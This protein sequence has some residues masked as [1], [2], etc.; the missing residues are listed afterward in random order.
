MDNWER[1]G[2]RL[3]VR[4][5]QRVAAL[6]GRLLTCKKQAQALVSAAKSERSRRFIPLEMV[7]RLPETYQDWCLEVYLRNSF[8]NTMLAQVS[9]QREWVGVIFREVG[10]KA[11]P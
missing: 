2:C 5:L 10:E 3:L 7:L 4:R 8:Y 1:F 9:T 11:I 6:Q